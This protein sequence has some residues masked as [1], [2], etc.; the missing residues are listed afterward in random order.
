[1]SESDDASEFLS[2]V[3]LEETRSYLQRGR[4]LESVQDSD[5]L[6]CW[7]AAFER[8][9]ANRTTENSRAMDDAAAGT[10]SVSIRARSSPAFLVP[11]TTV[12]GSAAR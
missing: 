11:L 9:L 8:R 4:L 7:I 10:W 1:M 2:H 3:E 5:I 6:D 12:R